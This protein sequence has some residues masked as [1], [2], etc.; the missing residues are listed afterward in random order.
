MGLSIHIT[1]ITKMKQGDKV[2]CISE[3]FPQWKTTDEDKTKN[4]T[5]PNNHPRKGEVLI[6]DEVLGVFIRFDKYDN[7]FHNWWMSD[8]F[9]K[10]DLQ[11]LMNGEEKTADLYQKL[12][13]ELN[14]N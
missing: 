9:R 2:V 14:N 11:E 4:G 7:D 5:Q 8:R 3:D 13:D 6:V 1:G 12:I 10:M